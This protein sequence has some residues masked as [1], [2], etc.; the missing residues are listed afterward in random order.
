[1]AVPKLLKRPITWQPALA[2]LPIILSRL[3]PVGT[4]RVDS[5]SD[6]WKQAKESRALCLLSAQQA[7][8]FRL[9]KCSR[10]NL[11]WLA[12]HDNVWAPEDQ[13]VRLAVY[14]DTVSLPVDVTLKRS[15]VPYRRLAS[16]AVSTAAC[17]PSRKSRLR[18]SRTVSATCLE[19]QRW[20]PTAATF[21]LPHLYRREVFNHDVPDWG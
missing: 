6:T 4:T 16:G 12:N 14:L 2:S 17:Y 3:S 13:D 21:C 9:M 19:G 18:V 1:V 10:P 5:A 15:W 8:G 7:T 20:R 11:H